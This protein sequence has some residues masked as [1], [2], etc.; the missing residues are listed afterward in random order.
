M[1]GATHPNVLLVTGLSGAGLSSALKCLED[2][3][4]EVFDNFPL[5]LLDALLAQSDPTQIP[6]AIGFDGRNRSFDP[7]GIMDVL[8]RLKALPK[9]RYRPYLLCLMAEDDVLQRRFTET[10]RR[11]PLAQDDRPLHDGIAAERASI[12]PLVDRADLVID[13]S[14][15]KLPD[16]QRLIRAHFS[17]EDE[18]PLN[19]TVMSFAFRNGLPREADL[20]F[21]VR[22]L[23]NPHWVDELR[24][25]TGQSSQVATYVEGDSAFEG[26]W[27]HVTGFLET[28]LPRYQDEGKHYLTVAFGCTGGK[29]RSVALAEKLQNW[30]KDQ[31]YPA[32]VQHRDMPV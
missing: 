5:A 10:R 17:P 29:H 20:V 30:F 28:A 32:R 14:A 3:G 12:A 25:Q 6:I 31:G 15:L 8:A 4:Y 18:L 11:H 1:T 24:P 27:T 9:E 16:L 22:F 26:L 7:A 19:I 2:E 21:D 13:T 23:R